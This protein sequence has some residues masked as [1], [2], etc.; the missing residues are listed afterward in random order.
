MTEETDGNWTILTRT[1]QNH[2]N[3]AQDL[4]RALLIDPVAHT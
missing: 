4:V 1:E 2:F 3:N